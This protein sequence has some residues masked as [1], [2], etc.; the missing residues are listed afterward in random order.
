M[1]KELALTTLQLIQ[2]TLPTQS[3]FDESQ[4][5]NFDRLLD[6]LSAQVTH[7]I[8]H[9]YKQLMEALYRI[10]VS[11]QAVSEILNDDPSLVSRNLA[12]AILERQLKKAA[13]R[14]KYKG[15]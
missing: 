6:W 3:E 2:L 15:W 9:D 12:R 7:L 11:E 8:D 1:D 10:D 14:I 13:T 5:F 4:E